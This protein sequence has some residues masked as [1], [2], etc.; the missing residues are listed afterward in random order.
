MNFIVRT[1]LIAGTML[2]SNTMETLATTNFSEEITTSINSTDLIRDLYTKTHAENYGLSFDAFLEGM[3]GYLNLIN[4]NKI[5]NTRVLSIVDFSQPSKNKRLYI[6][7]LMKGE[8]LINTYVAH[9][10][11][12]GLMY[13]E[14]FSNIIN[15]RKSSI[16]FYKAAETY[17]GKYGLSLKLDGLQRQLN[18]KAR[19]R[20]IV[21]HPAKY[22]SKHFLESN[23]YMGRS[24]GCPA[25]PYKEHKDIIQ[26]IKGGSVFYIYTNQEY[27]KEENL[28][29]LPDNTLELLSTY[30][31]S[32]PSKVQ[33][34]GLPDDM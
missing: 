10:R 16:G 13:A 18:H 17:R 14:K 5:K 26:A 29:S 3:T 9:G 32:F 4:E 22:V 30:T 27:K 23:G 8:L 15:S 2:S 19:E 20:A 25:V 24:Y 6:F 33:P 12:S 34:I 31:A 11:N 7:D 28:Y 1:L 21:M